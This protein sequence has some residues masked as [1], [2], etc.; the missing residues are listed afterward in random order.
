MP[1]PEQPAGRAD[2]RRAALVILL[3]GGVEQPAHLM[4]RR[5]AYLGSVVPPGA[6][7]FRRV[8]LA[9]PPHHRLLQRRLHD[10][11]RAGHRRRPRSA[12]SSAPLPQGGVE[13]V[14]VLH[15]QGGNLAVQQSLQVAVHHPPGLVRRRRRPVPRPGLTPAFLQLAERPRWRRHV[16]G[17][18]L[19]DEGGQRPFGLPLRALERW[20]L[21]DLLAGQRVATGVYPKYPQ[22]GRS[23]VHAPRRRA[24]CYLTRPA[25]VT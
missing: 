12:A 23:P 2:R 11:V 9:P 16:R 10:R 17:R 4:G 3:D 13:P 15:S 20:R 1:R 18:P 6:R 21:P 25:D 24:S 22:S 19:S 14:Q 8:V 5:R 7:P